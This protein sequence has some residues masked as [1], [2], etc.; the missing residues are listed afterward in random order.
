MND[1]QTIASEMDSRERYVLAWIEK[2]V[3][4]P[5]REIGGDTLDALFARG[6]V[7]MNPSHLPRA[8]WPVSCSELGLR[9]ICAPTTPSS[10]KRE[11]E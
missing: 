9:H 8:C 6:L 11:H 2:Q 7:M 1:E 10:P 3:A 4:M 5:Y